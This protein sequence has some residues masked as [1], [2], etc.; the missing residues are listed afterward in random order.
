[1]LGAIVSLASIFI[2]N[3]RYATLLV[4]IGCIGLSAFHVGVEKKWWKGP[5]ACRTNVID[6]QGL[7]P[8][9]AMKALKES[10]KNKQPVRCDEVNWAIFDV[11]ATI[12]NTLYLMMMLT[13]S[14]MGLCPTHCRKK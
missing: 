5:D 4:I 10:L 14:G 13:L 12:W 9:D 6:T 1:M 2:E 7:A 3:L 8:E 11:S